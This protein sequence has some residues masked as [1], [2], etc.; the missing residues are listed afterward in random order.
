M[1]GWRIGWS[2]APRAL[3]RAL[4]ALQSHTTS[5]AATPSQH[6]ALA[7][8]T[9]PTAANEATAAMVAEFRRRRDAARGM[10]RDAKID[11]IEPRGAFYLYARAGE[12]TTDDPE[13]GTTFARRLLEQHDVA[14]VPGAAFK[15]PEWIRVSYAAPADQVIEGV[16]R[17]IAARIS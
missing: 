13:P 9:N 16:R 15:S 4:S 5:N 12:S 6:A 1:T 10:L 8:L 2:I 11:V 17:I 14:V 7:A 3:T